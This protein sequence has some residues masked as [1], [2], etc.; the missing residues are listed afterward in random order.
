MGLQDVSL[1]R[2]WT[3][4]NRLSGLGDGLGLDIPRSYLV[5]GLGEIC[6]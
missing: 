1:E 3:T 2:P 6:W 5:K 4:S